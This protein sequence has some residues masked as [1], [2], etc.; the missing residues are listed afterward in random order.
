MSSMDGL[1][2]LVAFQGILYAIPTLVLCVV[3][4]HRYFSSISHIPG[5]FLGTIGTCFQVWEIFKGRI[6]YTLF[7][8]HQEHGPFLRISYNE[9]S[10]SHPDALKILSTPLRKAD[11]Y[12]PMA[13]PNS[14]YNNLMSE[15]DPKKYAAMRSN[16]ASA[17]TLS[18]VLRN[19][20]VIDQTITL[21]EDR[22]DEQATQKEPLELSRWLSFLTYDLLGEIL[23]SS[24]FGFLDQGRDVDDSIKNNFFLSVYIT[25]IVYMQW[26]HALLLGSPVLR[27]ID[28]Q[29]NEHT[30]TTAVNS[31]AARKAHSMPR[32]DMTQHW[33]EQ[34]QN[35]PE[36]FSERDLFSTVIGTFGAGGGT[37]GSVLQAFFYFL[38]KNP[39]YYERL[40]QEI[41]SSQLSRVV[42]FA[43]TQR[44]PYLQAVVWAQ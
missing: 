29:P 33:L 30:Y 3:L 37:V 39:V 11:F 13:V 4:K 21:F 7:Q 36:R 32:V 25:S 5:P 38:L 43:E 28:F 23:F 27:W 2:K 35:H 10:V 34:H 9:V 15:R 8:L 1:S 41:D 40:K 12:R 24:R 26:L 42:S 22:L 44:L 18:N 20:A 6:N 17:F 19:E 16:V 14:N 31:L